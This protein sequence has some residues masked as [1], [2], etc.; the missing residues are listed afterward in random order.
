VKSLFDAG[1]GGSGLRERLDLLLQTA[2]TRLELLGLELQEEKLRLARL[3]LG[4]VLAA[5]LLGFAVVFA[6][7]WLTVALWDTHRQLGL[8]IATFI[9]LAL[10]VGAAGVAAR[11]WAAGSRL[12]AAS[13][14][15]L[16][17]DRVAL[18]R[19]RDL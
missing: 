16:E 2:Q 1:G 14:A 19:R 6:L 17:S 8:G 4:T 12:F 15:E 13:L 18:E 9:T 7:I 5:V 10:G 11:A 3:L